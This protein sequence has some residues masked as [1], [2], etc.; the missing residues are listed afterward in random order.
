MA[1]NI[2][3]RLFRRVARSRRSVFDAELSDGSN[4][5]VCP[6]PIEQ[7]QM[8][9]LVKITMNVKDFWERYRPPPPSRAQSPRNRAAIG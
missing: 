2:R 8:E 6:V 1:R 4:R 5:N 7:R 3:L 9:I